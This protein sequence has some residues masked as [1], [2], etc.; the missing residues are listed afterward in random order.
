MS[1][2]EIFNVFNNVFL[3]FVF[4]SIQKLYEDQYDKNVILMMILLIKFN[5]SSSSKK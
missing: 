2:E 4:L 3:F 5:E 1:S